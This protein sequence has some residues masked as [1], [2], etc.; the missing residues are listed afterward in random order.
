M[1]NILNKK[2]KEEIIAQLVKEF[3][4][5]NVMEVPKL[6]KVVVNS[7]IGSF[8]DKREHV[9]NFVS[10]L[11]SLLGQKPYPRPAKKS[12]SGF[13]IRA[14]ELVGYAATLRND[15]MWA[16]TN[17]LLSVVLPRVRDFDGLSLNSFDQSGNYSLGIKEH[18]LFPEIDPNKVT[19]SRH[20][21]V[22]FVTDSDDINLNK[23]FFELLGFPFKKE[24]NK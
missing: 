7:G 1:D 20:L 23:R 12:E 5:S 3:K 14:G 21:Q 15:K 8:R 11:T 24:E 2:Y 13:K 16:F 19:A 6:K 4:L 9:E 10:E 22:T 17:K 18:S